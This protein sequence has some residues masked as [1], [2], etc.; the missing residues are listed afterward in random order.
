MLSNQTSN[1]LEEVKRLIQSGESLPIKRI[2]HSRGVHRVM[3]GGTIYYVEYNKNT[4]EVKE[5]K[6]VGLFKVGDR[7]EFKSYGK[8]FFGEVVG[9]VS[10]GK[11]PYQVCMKL[12]VKEEFGWLLRATPRGQVSYLVVCKFGLAT[13]LYWPQVSSMRKG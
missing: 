2:S 9:I 6:S 11:K 7:V 10:K 3:V 4:K 5:A 8:R 12:G 13:R 1:H